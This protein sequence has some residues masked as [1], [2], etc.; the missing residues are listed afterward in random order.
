[1]DK[2][3]KALD[4]LYKE[5][6]EANFVYLIIKGNFL[7]TKKIIKSI[8]TDLLFDENFDST[9]YKVQVS[10]SELSLNPLTMKEKLSKKVERWQL[11]Q[12][13]ELQ[14]LGEDDVL[15]GTKYMTTVQCLSPDSRLFQISRKDFM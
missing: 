10:N 12:M 14:F 13:G 5:K 15:F 11:L 2:E 3:P 7:V 6:Q 1:M 9:S 4:F 8:S